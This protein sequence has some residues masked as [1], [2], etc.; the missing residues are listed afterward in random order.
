MNTSNLTESEKRNNFYNNYFSSADYNVFRYDVGSFCTRKLIISQIKHKYGTL[1]EIGTGISSMLSDIKSSKKLNFDCFG[2]DI[3]DTTISTVKKQFDA[4]GIKAELKVADAE[5]LPF[6]DNTFDV[7]ISAH[8]LEHIKNDNLVIKECSRVLKPG[9]ELIIFVPGRKNGIATQ[10]EFSKFG[11]F[12]YYNKSKFQVIEN[13]TSP[14]L[15]ITK[16]IYPHKI[17]NLIWNRLK[18]LFRWTNYPIKKWIL[19]DNKTYEVRPTYQKFFLP[20]VSKTLN[21]L[22][23]TTMHTEKN[24]FGAEF[25]VLVKFEQRR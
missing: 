18:N 5:S 19:R 24:F 8:T 10:E 25:N 2:V 15:K 11:H 4:L 17:H 23:K 16:L 6:P 9:G 20:A 13:A 14:D 12:R 7:I 1:L 21:L 3:S 22:D